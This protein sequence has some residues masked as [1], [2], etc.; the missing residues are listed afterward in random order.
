MYHRIPTN[1]YWKARRASVNIL[2]SVTWN[3][4]SL[5]LIA[6]Y[7]CHVAPCPSRRSPC[8]FEPN[9]VILAT[10]RK[11]NCDQICVNF[12]QFGKQFRGGYSH[13]SARQV[14]AARQDIVLRI[15]TPLAKIQAR[16]CPAS[17]GTNHLLKLNQ[18]ISRC[19]RRCISLPH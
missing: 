13:M 6:L 17:S 5:I 2:T 4:P 10:C 19:I 11:Q 14:C 15:L 8:T 12:L 7:V 18:S 9:N 1:S 16:K 3:W